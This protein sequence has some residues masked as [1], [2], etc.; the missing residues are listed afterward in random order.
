MAIE[1]TDVQSLIV[2]AKKHLKP[3]DPAYQLLQ[4]YIRDV[5]YMLPDIKGKLTPTQEEVYKRLE[6]AVG[7]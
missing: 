7:P 1:K 2:K 3:D 6:D 5:E 4:S